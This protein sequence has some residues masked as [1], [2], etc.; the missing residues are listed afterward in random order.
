M[1]QSLTIYDTH[2]RIITRKENQGCSYCKRVSLYRVLESSG[3]EIG[4]R[5]RIFV[6][7]KLCNRMVAKIN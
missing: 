2:T 1:I 4:N 3:A 5:S 7:E 6:T